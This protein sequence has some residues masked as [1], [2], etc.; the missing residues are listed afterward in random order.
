MARHL[1]HVGR[2]VGIHRQ[3]FAHCCNRL[4]GLTAHFCQWMVLAGSEQGAILAKVFG[5]VEFDTG[6]QDRPMGKNAL[7]IRDFLGGGMF[8]AVI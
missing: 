6:R 8:L 3:T 1:E 5:T 7:R 4:V 2:Y